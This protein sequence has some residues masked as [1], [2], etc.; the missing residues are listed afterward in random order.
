M[1]TVFITPVD[2]IFLTLIHKIY[3]GNA[4]DTVNKTMHNTIDI[5]STRRLR[6]SIAV[7]EAEE[8]CNSYAHNYI[9]IPVFNVKDSGGQQIAYKKRGG[10]VFCRN[11]AP[12]R[13]CE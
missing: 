2:S 5:C 12:L 3:T 13:N 10:F 8:K 6:R 4:K 1:K 9:K 7:G 11:R